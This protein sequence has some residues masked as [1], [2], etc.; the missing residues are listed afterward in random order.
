MGT[1][2]YNS[3]FL[4]KENV[5]TVNPILTYNLF[6]LL[7]MMSEMRARLSTEY[8]QSKQRLL[9]EKEMEWTTKVG[10]K[11]VNHDSLYLYH[12]LTLLKS[13]KLFQA[14]T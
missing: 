13:I 2:M 8:Q 9:K 7:Q 6:H 10:A 1:G 3:Q 14:G 5:S 12:L 4:P 11:S